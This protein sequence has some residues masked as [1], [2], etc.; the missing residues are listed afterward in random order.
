MSIKVKAKAFKSM[1]HS[2]GFDI[3]AFSPV[4]PYS[5]SL[6]LSKYMTFSCKGDLSWCSIGKEYELEIEEIETNKYG[7]TYSVVSVP[8][9]M[10]NLKDLTVAQSKELLMDFTTE[11]QAENILS[12]YPDFIYKIVTEG[13][14][15]IDIKK[16]HNV[17][18]VYLNA[19]AREI[20]TRY[21]YFGIIE[22]IKEWNIDVTDCKKLVDEFLDEINIVEAFKES[23]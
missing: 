5:E 15:S 23:P 12:A 18:E 17:G 6:K 1:Y 19:Y 4:Y 22:K 8:S 16:I 20:N 2:T 21:K 10:I 7:T 11:R 14:E 3:I 9:L 13:K